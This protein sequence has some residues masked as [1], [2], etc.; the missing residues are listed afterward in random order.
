MWRTGLGWM[1]K[2]M[3]INTWTH[4]IWIPKLSF[5]YQNVN[6]I[7][8]V[9]FLIYL[10]VVY[11]HRKASKA[12]NFLY[13]QANFSIVLR[14][15][16]TSCPSQRSSNMTIFPEGIKDRVE[17]E[18]EHECKCDCEQEPEAVSIYLSFVCLS[19]QL[20]IQLPGFVLS[21]H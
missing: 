8:D 10:F 3:Q 14:S 5:Y 17:I 11:H 9:N 12:R 7:T 16:M 20:S 6:K 15:N 18:V 19:I 4:L 2:Y 13:K 21:K 1:G